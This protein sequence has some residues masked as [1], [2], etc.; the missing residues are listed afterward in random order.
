MS[1][2]AFTLSGAPSALQDHADFDAA[3]FGVAMRQKASGA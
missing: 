3:Y 1:H 2:G